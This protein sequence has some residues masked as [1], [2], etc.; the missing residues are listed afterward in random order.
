MYIIYILYYIYTQKGAFI[1]L[2]PRYT[3]KASLFGKKIFLVYCRYRIDC[4]VT[5]YGAPCKAPHNTCCAVNI[6]TKSAVYYLARFQQ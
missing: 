1:Y 6:N 2:K 3:Q 4:I 5:A